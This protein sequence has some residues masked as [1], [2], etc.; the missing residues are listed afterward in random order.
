MKERTET[1]RG[2]LIAPSVLSADF[3]HLSEQVALVEAAG[4]E[5]LHLDVMDGHFVPNITFG[6]FIVDAI[7]RVTELFLD[8]H[9]MITD[10]PRYAERF[11][12]AGAD[13]LIV[14]I[15][16]LPDPRPL[17]KEIRAMGAQPALV[18]NP[19]TPFERAEPYLDAIDLLLVM[20]VHPGFGGQKFM[21]EVLPKV[22]RARALRAERG[23]GFVIE[24]DGGIDVTT[25]PLAA[26][27][28]VD[29][30]VAGNAIFGAADPAE[31]LRAIRRAAEAGRGAR[32]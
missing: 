22:E 19:E 5:L 3:G 16:T 8:V 18:L 29:V 17:L 30:F 26:A 14:Q 15:E 24:I 23:L 11:V 12:A 13:R 6:P 31:A 27:A 21:G 4:A 28:G 25:A 2:V 10:A 7:N 1:G 9:L 32:A 20:S